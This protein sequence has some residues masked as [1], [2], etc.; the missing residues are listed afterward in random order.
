MDR[1]LCSYCGMTYSRFGALER[2]LRL[3]HEN[4]PKFFVECVIDKCKS[5]F[6]SVRCL[7]RHVERYHS[8]IC[9]GW[10]YQASDDY[11][12][13]H[14]EEPLPVDSVEL[15]ESYESEHDISSELTPLAAEQCGSIEEM[16]NSYHMQLSQLLLRMSEV[17]VLPSIVQTDLASSITSLVSSVVSNYKQ[18]ICS[19]LMQNE[20]IPTGDEWE[21]VTDTERMFDILSTAVSSRCGLTNYLKRHNMI[22]EPREYTVGLQSAGTY[23]YVPILLVL[24]KLLSH[25]DVHQHIKEQLHASICRSTN[26]LESFYDGQIYK[27]SGYF[28]ENPAALQVQL[29]IDELELCNPIG[30]KRGRHKV[31]AI[32]YVIGN[33]HPRFRTQQRFIHLALLVRHKLIKESGDNYSQFL[34]PLIHDLKIL[35]T[36]GVSVSVCGCSVNMKGKV[37]SISADNLSAHAVGGFQQHFHSG[38]ICRFCMVDYEDIASCYSES[39]C[40]VRTADRHA[41]HVDAV[42]Q[43]SLNSKVY[44]VKKACAFSDLPAF[45]VST[46]FPPDVMHDLLEGVMPSVTALLLKNFVAAGLFTFADVNVALDKLVVPHRQNMPNKL[47]ESVPRSEISIGGT[48]IQKLEL[49]LVLPQ[50]IAAYIAEGNEV[51]Y[52]YVLLREICDIILAP[53]VDADSI[54]LLESLIESF[55]SAFVNIFGP[56]KV[57]PKMHYLVHYPRF[58]R[59]FGPLRNV[60]CMRFEAKHQYFKK[61]AASTKCFK[62][63]CKTLCKRHQLLQCWEMSSTEMLLS[64]D[65]ATSKT[66]TLPFE[67]LS[68]DIKE[69]ITAVVQD[70]VALDENVISSKSVSIDHVLY[71]QNAVYVYTTVEEE[72][73]PVM[74]LVKFVFCIR[75][76]W[77][78][79]GHLLIPEK[80]SEHYYAYQVRQDQEWVACRPGQFADHTMHDMFDTDGHTYVSLRYH[81]VL[82]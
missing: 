24:S 60:W 62:N 51:W 66:K 70:D 59:L 14:I 31:T 81:C 10:S 20:S 1:F 44:G 2:H 35:Q 41:Y 26:I 4:S 5:C 78:L 69:A 19:H 43:N 23:H 52:V 9:R 12:V 61:V 28:T 48:A 29:Y 21:T 54:S 13:G 16:L 45:D 46:S 8:D 64:S 30:A 3:L 25:T 67:N 40:T 6:K 71:K 33:I 56:E 42:T 82:H 11:Q 79:C 47:P 53:V 50:L 49:F 55:M 76:A 57:I 39:S 27:S 32:Y 72:G 37:I 17:H 58:M 63:I 18:V 74:F 36:E 68:S 65:G 34:Q 22:V 73:V 7:R 38:R 77:I 75:T 80:F 15:A